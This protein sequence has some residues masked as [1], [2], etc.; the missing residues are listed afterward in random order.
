MPWPAKEAEIAALAERNG[1]KRSD[2]VTCVQCGTS[3]DNGGRGFR[4]LAVG[5]RRRTAATDGTCIFCGK[6]VDT[7]DPMYD[8]NWGEI[9]QHEKCYNDP[10]KRAEFDQRPYWDNAPKTSAWTRT[11]QPIEV[12]G[13]V[14]DVTSWSATDG[15]R[16]LTVVAANG[17]FTWAVFAPGQATPSRTGRAATL[18]AAQ[19]ACNEEF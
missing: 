17:G 19:A 14:R 6:P 7:T 2:V 8:P 16:D 3:F 1:L 5:T 4:A 15:A 13:S 9:Q 11:R 10:A 18:E 12:E